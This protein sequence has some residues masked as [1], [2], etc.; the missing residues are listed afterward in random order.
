VNRALTTSSAHS[1]RRPLVR[2]GDWL[3]VAFPVAAIVVA[4]AVPMP[5]AI[6]VATVVLVTVWLAVN[7][8]AAQLE[9]RR[10][11]DRVDSVTRSLARQS[12]LDPLTGLPNRAAVVDE[13]GRRAA[14]TDPSGHPGLLLIGLDGIDGVGQTLGHDQADAL[15]LAMIERLR[16]ALGHGAFLG[17]IDGG[18]FAVVPDGARSEP[19]DAL[20]AHLLAV[21]AA[22]QEL[23]SGEVATTAS[24]GLVPPGLGR[25]RPESLELLRDASAALGQA[26]RAGGARIEIYRPDVDAA[27]L[28]N[29]RLAAELRRAIPDRELEVYYQPIV[30]L[31]DRRLAGAEALI[32]WN[33]PHQGVLTPDRWLEVADT[34]G[35]LPEI[36][37]ATLDEVCRRFATVGARA[38][39]RP[40]RIAVNLA[41]SE[42]RHPDLV[43]A[44]GAILDRSGLDA[45][46]LVV[47]V[48]DRAVLDDQSAQAIIELRRLGVR[49]SL[50]DFG[51]GLAAIG[52]LGHLP[53]DELKLD[54]SVVAQAA[55][56]GAEQAVLEA[57]IGLCSRLGIEV[58]A[59]GVS[60]ERDADA[61]AA[62]GCQYAQGWMFGRPIPFSR[63]VALLDR[64]QAEPLL[65]PPAP[66]GAAGESGH[67][68]G[69]LS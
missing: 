64:M 8:V 30:S 2:F 9:G 62:L 52:R 20:A 68:L 69:E 65:D 38:G 58:V 59:E 15:I 43:P 7:F 26:R 56:G 18:E 3:R 60:T 22:P 36:G 25:G 24:I 6:R 4:V 16:G 48:S 5:N 42:L 67:P 39:D 55:A 51:T 61:L 33:H 28:D 29:L 21:I 46:Q 23:A 35:L 1:R 45:T 19:I 49:I 66:A 44:L 50:D 11:A 31:P 12:G 53:I 41:P 17:R 10:L 27:A 13:L 54:D 63:F 14:A 47:E 34:A 57:V 37:R 32:R 40:L